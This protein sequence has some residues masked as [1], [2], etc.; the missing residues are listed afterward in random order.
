MEDLD[1]LALVREHLVRL[2]LSHLAE[3]LPDDLLAAGQRRG[4]ELLEEAL[5]GEMESRTHRR[6]ARLMSEAKLPA[7]KRFES[8]EMERFPLTLQDQLRHLRSGEFLA[9]AQNVLCFGLPGT[10]KTHTAC[11]LAADLIRKGHRVRF[12][13]TF[14]LVQELL[15]ARRDLALPRALK[16]LERYELLILD[17]LGYVEQSA[18]QI[19]VLF[20]LLAERYERRSVLLTSNL[21][22]SQWD[23]IFKDPMTTAAAT[24]RLV[25]HAHILEF[26]VSSYRSAQALHTT[27]TRDVSGSSTSSETTSPSSDRHSD[28]NRQV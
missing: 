10:G 2:R 25:H 27:R 7:G 9:R 24:D 15:A 22:F 16:K 26:D 18:E 19:E 1:L 21:V 28:D 14:A 23:K 17:D 13:P 8:L 6:I 11:A 5:D 20:T 3:T 4:L 12:Y